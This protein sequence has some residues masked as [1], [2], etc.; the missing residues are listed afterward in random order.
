MGE[1]DMIR[2]MEGFTFDAALNLS[3][4]YY[5]IKLDADA[6]KLCTI[7]FPWNTGKYKHKHLPM[8]IKIA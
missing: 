8:C 5:H 2:S 4:G 1:A 6:Q 7:V 3:I